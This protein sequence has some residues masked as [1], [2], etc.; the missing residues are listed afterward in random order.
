MRAWLGVLVAALALTATACVSIEYGAMPRTQNLGKLS[1]G[2]SGPSDI[3]A[4]LGQPRG[5]GVARLA[6]LPE[7]RAIWYYEYT[8]SDGSRVELTMLL[9]FLTDDRYDGHLWFS[10]AQLVQQEAW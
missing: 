3:L 5:K 7:P 10:S 9:V 4:A 6:G 8:R 1:V 2:I